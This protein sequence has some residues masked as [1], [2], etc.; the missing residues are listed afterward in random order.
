MI[1]IVLILLWVVIS[2]F[3]NLGAYF[4]PTPLGVGKALWMHVLDG[5]LLANLSM[6]LGRVLSSV[7]IAAVVGIPVGVLAGTSRRVRHLVMPVVEFARGIP[8]SMLFPVFIV[9]VG[10][11]ESAKI[12]IALYGTIPVFIVSAF[13]G[14]VPRPEV[15]GRRE[16][17]MLH[18]DQIS[19]AN[20]AMCL[21][22]EAV[23][24]LVSGTKLALSL[25][26][27]LVIVTEMFF[28]ADAGAGWAAYQAYNAF[29]FDE[30]YAYVFVIG[31]VGLTA[32]VCLD[33]AVRRIKI[34]T[35]S[36]E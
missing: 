31:L 32:N 23:P 11:G 27:V 25:A 10:F 18:K 3:V 33:W 20:R 34:V 28:V 7:V 1:V 15:L 5:S 19:R 35:E 16:Y 6:T 9:L 36:G 8:T 12:A 26:L 22:W 4:L 29:A 13:V 30:M 17:L 21:L 14:V 2:L 24:S